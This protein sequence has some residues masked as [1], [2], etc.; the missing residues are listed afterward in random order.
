MS[1]NLTWPVLTMSTPIRVRKLDEQS[2]GQWPDAA[3]GKETLDK[4]EREEVDEEGEEV[5]VAEADEDKDSGEKVFLALGKGEPL[6]FDKELS[7][8]QGGPALVILV[9]KVW[10]KDIDIGDDDDDDDDDDGDDLRL[11]E[12]EGRSKSCTR[13]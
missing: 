6:S 4:E 12:R 10:C 7:R 8:H 9:I 5:D 1:F 13:S 3:S 11:S 2:T